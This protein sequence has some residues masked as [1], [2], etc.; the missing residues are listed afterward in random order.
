VFNTDT[1][2]RRWELTWLT[3]PD[4]WSSG[5]TATKMEG[6]VFVFVLKRSVIRTFQFQS[7]RTRARSKPLFS[8]I[9]LQRVSWK[10]IE[11][12]WVHKIQVMK[13]KSL[14]NAFS[15]QCEF[16]LWHKSEISLMFSFPGVAKVPSWFG[17]STRFRTWKIKIFCKFD[18]HKFTISLAFFKLAWH[19]CQGSLFRTRTRPVYQVDVSL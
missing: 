1:W 16:G 6:S 15:V 10:R 12:Q 5:P 4:R 3:R 19:V 9:Y 2:R 17:R 14:P 13:K 11:S 18:C 7:R 8:S